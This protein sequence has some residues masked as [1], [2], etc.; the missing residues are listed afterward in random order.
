MTIFKYQKHKKF[1]CPAIKY[2]PAVYLYG[3]KIIY[4]SLRVTFLHKTIS[5]IFDG[6]K[7]RNKNTR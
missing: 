5:I 3:E 7:R 1:S 6:D 4:S 2:F